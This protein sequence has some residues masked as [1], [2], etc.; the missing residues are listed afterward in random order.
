M[1][2]THKENI[3]KIGLKFKELRLLKGY[4]RK[5]LSEKTG[6]SES[7]IK[8]FELTG[9]ISLDSLLK[10]SNVLNI[11]NWLTCILEEEHFS[12]IDE[13]VKTKNK[14]KQRGTI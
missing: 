3:E 5:T 9:E 10:I 12:S 13:I 1:L 2:N 8:R 11:T 7:S 6:V 14:T 4:K